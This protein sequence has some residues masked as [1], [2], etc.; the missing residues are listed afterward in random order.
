MGMLKVTAGSIALRP[1]SRVT[2]VGRG[3]ILT[4]SAPLTLRATAMRARCDMRRSPPPLLHK[5]GLRT[6]PLSWAARTTPLTWAAPV[7]RASG[8]LDPRDAIAVRADR[9]FDDLAA[10][11]CLELEAFAALLVAAR[12]VLV[13]HRLLAR[14]LLCHRAARRHRARGDAH[15]RAGGGTQQRAA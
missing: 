12:L 15:A 10:R 6:T 11:R 7:N 1:A 8:L 2:P 4:R 13:V 3:V 5:R 14:L 9:A